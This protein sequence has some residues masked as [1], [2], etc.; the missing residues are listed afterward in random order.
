MEATLNGDVKKWASGTGNSSGFTK[1]FNYANN[2]TDRTMYEFHIS[3][4]NLLFTP[5]LLIIYGY[6]GSTEYITMFE[7]MGYGVNTPTVKVF[8]VSAN[9]YSSSTCYNFKYD[10]RMTANVGAGYYTF[11]VVNSSI[12]YKWIAFE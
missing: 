3:T 10:S 6:S 9:T 2:S 5:K 11:P 12:S 7:D 8:T 1:Y 4:S